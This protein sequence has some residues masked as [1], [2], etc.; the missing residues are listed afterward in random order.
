M[1]IET[2]KR[3][4]SVLLCDSQEDT[5]GE[6]RSIETLRSRTVD[7]LVLCPVGRSADHLRQ[8]E[9]GDLPVVLVDRYFPNLHL[10][11]VTSDNFGGAREATNHLIGNGHRRIACVQGIPG[12]STNDERA[13]GYRK[14]LEEHRIPWDESLVVGGSFDEQ[15]GYVGTKLL[16]RRHKDISAMFAFSNVISLGVLRALAEEGRNVPDDI[17]IISFDDQPYMAQWTPPLTVVAQRNLEMGQIAVK[18]L[19][20]WIESPTR[21]PREGVQ[22]PTS[23]VAR[24]SVKRRAPA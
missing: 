9:D 7:G 17:S 24:G 21:A 20:D 23:F 8:F 4:Y 5:D 6:I 14:A 3:G 15:N 1:A 2:R 13:C 11:Y 22:L 12:T 10:P 18:L 16:L 19:F